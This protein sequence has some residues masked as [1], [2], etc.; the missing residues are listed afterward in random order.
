M[1]FQDFTD[2]AMVTFEKYMQ[3]L[4]KTINSKLPPTIGQIEAGMGGEWTSN[5]FDDSQLKPQWATL[6]ATPFYEMGEGLPVALDDM[7]GNSIKNT[8][9]PFVITGDLDKDASKYIEL[10]M[11]F[12]AIV[13]K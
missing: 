12:L 4:I 13:K 6:F 7:D 9:L 5:I 1:E 10:I 3:D 11:I 8:T 2:A